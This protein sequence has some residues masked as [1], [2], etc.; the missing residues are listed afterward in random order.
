MQTLAQPQLDSQLEQLISSVRSVRNNALRHD[1]R[2]RAGIVAG[3]FA[4]LLLELREGHT[5]SRRN[6]RRF[7][8]HVSHPR[9]LPA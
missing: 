4:L 1:P 6:L 5:P 2:N 9:R 3:Q 8:H 7:F